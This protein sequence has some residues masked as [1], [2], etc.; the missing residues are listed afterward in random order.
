MKI[1]LNLLLVTP[2]EHC[3]SILKGN[4]MKSR[5]QCFKLSMVSLITN[6]LCTQYHL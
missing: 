2:T 4:N 3:A 6:E 1:A 5:L